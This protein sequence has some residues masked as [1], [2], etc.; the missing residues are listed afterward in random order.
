MYKASNSGKA[1]LYDI[2]TPLLDNPLVGWVIESVSQVA[3]LASA[4]DE[5]RSSSVLPVSFQNSVGRHFFDE[6]GPVFALNQQGEV[7]CPQIYVNI[8]HKAGAPFPLCLDSR[9]KPNVK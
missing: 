4:G 2:G 1:Q 7:P 5:Q 8:L 6:E 9:V 3:F